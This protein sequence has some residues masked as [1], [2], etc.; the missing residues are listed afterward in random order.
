MPSS[1]RRLFGVPRVAAHAAVTSIDDA[2]AGD[3]ALNGH[4]LSRAALGAFVVD[5][6]S[7]I[8]KKVSHAQVLIKLLETPDAAAERGE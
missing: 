1:G 5:A 2:V 8:G 4:M 3:D 7:V 6:R